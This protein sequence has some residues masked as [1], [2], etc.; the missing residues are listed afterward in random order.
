MRLKSFIRLIRKII[1]FTTFILKTTTI[2]LQKLFF[3]IHEVPFVNKLHLH[4]EKK[5][6]YYQPLQ[7]VCTQ[8][9]SLT[10]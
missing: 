8:Q 6:K 1:K 2:R 7:D 9:S 4:F 10:N 5:K 3:Q